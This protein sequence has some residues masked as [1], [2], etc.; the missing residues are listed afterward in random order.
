MYISQLGLYC[1]VVS[2]I[3]RPWNFLNCLSSIYVKAIQIKALKRL[4]YDFRN[5][6]GTRFDYSWQYVLK[7]TDRNDLWI[8]RNTKARMSTAFIQECCVVVCSE[9]LIEL[10]HKVFD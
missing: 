8:S 9:R 4:G 5:G 6:D 10:F 1:D 7:S 3:E 2:D